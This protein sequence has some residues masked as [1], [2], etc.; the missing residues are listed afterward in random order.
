M[1]IV[2][3]RVSSASVDIAGERVAAIG[4]GL[5]V[6]LGIA[7]GDGPEQ[8]RWLAGKVARLRVFADQRG[9]MNLDVAAAGGALLV[10]SQ[11]TLLAATAAGNRPSFTAAAG[12]EVAEPLYRAFIEEV[13]RVAG[14]PVATGRF[15]ADMQVGLV[16]DGP[17]TL[18]IDTAWRE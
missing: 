14:V 2:V 8:V 1:R 9:L 10:V 11:F 6:L 17:V 5:L 4:S 15:A 18:I 3:Q 16:N 12:R 7:S 13:A